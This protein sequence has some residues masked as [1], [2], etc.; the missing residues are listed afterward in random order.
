[1]LA[2][3][4][5]NDQ[6]EQLYIRSLNRSIKAMR[7]V[8]ANDDHIGRYISNRDL[9]TGAPV[10]PGG[11][12][13]TDETYAR[14]LADVTSHP[15]NVVPTQLKH[16][17][18]AYYANPDAPIITKKN[19][20]QWAAVQANLTILASMKTIGPLDPTPDESFYQEQDSSATTNSASPH[21]N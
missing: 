2:I 20:K 12:P 14:L 17:L 19:P 13:F 6:T 9:D 16:D 15:H 1:M 3:K 18:A 11:Y 21:S 8:L 10:R 5:P 4:G 7:F